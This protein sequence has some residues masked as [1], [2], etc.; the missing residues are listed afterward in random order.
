MANLKVELGGMALRNP[1]LTASGTFGYGSEY[2][3]I[4][5]FERLGGITVKGVSPFVSYGNPMPRTCEVYGGM[6]NAIGL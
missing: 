3:G 2:A 5:P 6:L 1:I 4:V